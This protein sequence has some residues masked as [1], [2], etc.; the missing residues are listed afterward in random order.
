VGN[1]ASAD[2]PGV[3]IGAVVGAIG[4][5][6]VRAERNPLFT[7]VVAVPDRPEKTTPDGTT[8]PIAITPI[9]ASTAGRSPVA[10]NIA[11]NRRRRFMM[12]SSASP[13]THHRLTVAASRWRK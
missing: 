10:G 2:E 1:P 12:D 6:V 13:A 11:S 3:A 9:S 5:F 7:D 4:A 8:T